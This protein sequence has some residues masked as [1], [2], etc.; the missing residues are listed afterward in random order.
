MGLCLIRGLGI[1]HYRGDTMNPSKRVVA[2]DTED[3]LVLVYD[4]LRGVRFGSV[5]LVIHD[6]RVVQIER[7]E[8]LR[9]D[10]GAA[11]DVLP[12]RT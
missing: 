1:T 6:G 3:V 4:A 2:P 10:K 12:L 7:R 8:R 11:H 9:L 5:E